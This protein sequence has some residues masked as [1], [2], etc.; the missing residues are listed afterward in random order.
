[1]KGRLALDKV[2]KDDIKNMLLS[3]LSKVS[4]DEN[5]KN[6]MCGLVDNMMDTLQDKDFE[7]IEKVIRDYMKNGIR[8]Q[9]S[10]LR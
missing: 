9:E 5:Q 3:A 8:K 1:M 4:S 7:E 6:V 10:F 2:K